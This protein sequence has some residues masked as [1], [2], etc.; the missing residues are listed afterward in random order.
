[1]IYSMTGF[2]KAELQ[3]NGLRLSI[4]L[5]SLNS[6]SF[7]FKARLPSNYQEKEHEIKE[8]VQKALTRGKIDLSVELEREDG[9]KGL[10]IQEDVVLDYLNQLANI[11]H[12]S[13]F[14]LT[15][16]IEHVLRLPEVIKPPE[17]EAD[18]QEFTR[19]I[20]GIDLAILGFNEFR[21]AEGKKL[22][23]DLIE[24]LDHIEEAVR[25]V[26]ALKEERLEK[27]R[28]SLLQKFEEFKVELDQNRLE[29]EMIYYIEK[30]D[31]NEELVRLKS[32]C[33]YFRE[34]MKLE[35]AQG[36][37][38]GFIAQELGREINTLGAKAYHSE[39][40]KIVVGMKDELE[41]IKEQSLNIL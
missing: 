9:A 32:H 7:D 25:L 21:L 35:G 8:R 20:E 17:M 5:K 39:I 4:E 40:Q 33:A 11:E 30:L 38:L 41:K 36:R 13:G 34:T 14:K 22:E 6:K 37:K 15:Q 12:K 29:Q 18:D 24:R 3:L 27:R 31:I 26:E 16:A 23:A 19:I 10:V 1:M 2:G 28:E